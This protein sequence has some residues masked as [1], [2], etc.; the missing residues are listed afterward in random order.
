LVTHP[1]NRGAPI[2]RV[3]MVEYEQIFLG[4]SAFCDVS[5]LFC[6]L[7]VIGSRFAPKYHTVEPIMVFE[8]EK[9]QQTEAIAIEP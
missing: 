6:K 5:S 7:E 2:R 1:L 9:Q 3:G 4:W 8:F